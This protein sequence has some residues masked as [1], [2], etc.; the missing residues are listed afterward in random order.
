M[1]VRLWKPWLRLLM[2]LPALFA[3][4]A[5]SSPAICDVL[6]ITAVR[7]SEAEWKK[8]N[9]LVAYPQTGLGHRVMTANRIG[10]STEN[11][12]IATIKSEFYE[13]GAGGSYDRYYR[14]VCEKE[15]GRWR[16]NPALDM[17]AIKGLADD[18][19]LKNPVPSSEIM[20]LVEYLKT[21]NW[22]GIS[23]REA[24]NQM[25]LRSI[26]RSRSWYEI[27]VSGKD[28]HCYWGFRI[29]RA[30]ESELHMEGPSAR[31]CE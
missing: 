29:D 18:V 11:G 2:S 5:I 17:V 14:V 9:E 31:L 10:R 16:C 12:V 4:I 1:S 7:L 8:V 26:W 24:P 23:A 25:I 3:C 22:P 30:P 20:S 21:Q 28:M 19:L 27:T 15:K 13:R 6:P